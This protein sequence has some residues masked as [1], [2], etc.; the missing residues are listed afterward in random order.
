MLLFMCCMFVTPCAGMSAKLGRQ[1]GAGAS[2]VGFSTITLPSNPV[3][4]Q[5]T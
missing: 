2:K 4:R 3:Q 1:D 5:A